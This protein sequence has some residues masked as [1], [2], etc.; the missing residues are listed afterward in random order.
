MD[1]RGHIIHSDQAARTL[2]GDPGETWRDGFGVASPEQ[3]LA[4]VIHYAQKG[5]PSHGKS[6]LIHSP[7]VKKGSVY[8]DLLHIARNIPQIFIE[9]DGAKYMYLGKEGHVKEAMRLTNRRKPELM[10]DEE[11]H[12]KV[13]ELL[14]YK[15]EAIEEFIGRI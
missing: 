7:N 6:L 5:Y 11:Q 14:G 2:I 1:F 12:R 13:G 15:K 3:E 4:A 9:I 10:A 8:E